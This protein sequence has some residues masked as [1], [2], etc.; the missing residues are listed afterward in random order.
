MDR[1]AA[2]AY[3]LG[4]LKVFEDDRGF[5]NK[6]GIDTE[7][8]YFAARADRQRLRGLRRVE[9]DFFER[10]AFSSSASLTML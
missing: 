4:L 7:Y 3:L 1:S 8:R 10:Q 6:S 2:A 5:V 9:G